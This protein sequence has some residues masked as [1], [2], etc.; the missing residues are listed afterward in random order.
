[1]PREAPKSDL[2]REWSRFVKFAADFVSTSE[3]M[4]EEERKEESEREEGMME[5][6]EDLLDVMLGNNTTTSSQSVKSSQVKLNQAKSRPV[7]R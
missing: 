4:E 1:M 5:A 3:G 2:R 6:R 7:G